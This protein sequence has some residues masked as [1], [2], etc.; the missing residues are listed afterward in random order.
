MGHAC[1]ATRGRAQRIRVGRP[2]PPFNKRRA[3]SALQQTRGY[4]HGGLVA[5]GER[6]LVTDLLHDTLLP[7]VFGFG[8][9]PRGI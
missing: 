1:D 7:S 5:D 8:E 6:Q 4:E 9:R 2:A 3:R